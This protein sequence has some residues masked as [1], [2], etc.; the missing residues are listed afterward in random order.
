MTLTP[1]RLTLITYIAQAC[2]AGAR[3]HSACQLVGL[4]IRTHQRWCNDAP[5]PTVSAATAATIT[6]ATTATPAAEP[7]VP[8]PAPQLGGDRRCSSSR[9]SFTPRNKLS[10]AERQI[11]I[12]TA[13]SE[14]YKNL[15]PCQIVPR[16]ADHLIY[17]AC[18]S[19]MYRIL[20]A[21]GQMGHRRT[22]RKGHQRTKPLA[23]VASASNQVYSW[24]ITYLPTTVRGQYFYLY[25]YV[26]LFSRKIVGWQVFAVE[27]ADNAAALLAHICHQEGIGAHQLTLHSDNGAPMKGET[28]LAMMQR[29]KVTPSRS[30]PSVS[31][32]N[33]YSE[34]L[35]HTIKHRPALPLRPFA[36]LAHAR[37]WVT[38]MVAWYNEEHR[39]S[40]IRFVTPSQR[41]AG[42]DRAILLQRHQLFEQA[43]KQNPQRWSGKT[44]CWE[45]IDCVHLNPETKP[46][47]EPKNVQ[48]LTK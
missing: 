33:P 22:E 3:R 17:L 40:A 35:F 28:M 27:S 20:K 36:D 16:L 29:L 10:D 24:D 39:H 21:A 34:S 5:N 41:H 25:L 44:R 15:S 19:T 4:S 46:K 11:I 6:S 2:A 14:P 38:A 8:Q 30:R 23:L 9:R 43:R 48:I 12:D 45:Y 18:V 7:S 32:D 37:R 13:N 31:N 47:K 1:Q 42:L 26:D